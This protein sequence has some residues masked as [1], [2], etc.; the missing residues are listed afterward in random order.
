MRKAIR[1]IRHGIC[2]CLL[3]F[4]IHAHHAHA[5]AT[6]VVDSTDG[7]TN[8]GSSC[9]I[10]LAVQSVLT[11][12]ALGG[13][14]AGSPTGN[15]ISFNIPG[16]PATIFLKQPI[17]ITDDFGGLPPG[18]HP[19]AGSLA[20]TGQGQVITF[21]AS[22]M[23]PADSM[24]IVGASSDDSTR[25]SRSLTFNTLRFSNGRAAKGAAIFSSLGGFMQHDCPAGIPGKEVAALAVE[26]SIFISNR[27][28]DA[29]GAIYVRPR[30]ASAQSL[31]C[32]P[33]AQLNV[34]NS[35]FGTNFA[36]RCGG[37]ICTE[38]PAS[39]TVSGKVTK[40]KG[41]AIVSI[42]SSSF[43]F[44]SVHIDGVTQTPSG[45]GGAY[46]S[47]SL[48][49]SPLQTDIVNSTFE[50]NGAAQGA[51]ISSTSGNV[52]PGSLGGTY[53]RFVTIHHNFLSPSHGYALAVSDPINGFY[54]NGMA[55]TSSIVYDT[56]ATNTCKFLDQVDGSFDDNLGWPNVQCPSGNHYALVADPLFGL[57][58][59]NG[60]PTHTWS[61][62]ATS[63]ALNELSVRLAENCP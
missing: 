37:A 1:F 3:G 27:S 5:I 39:I 50:N 17:R 33:V 22:Q 24:F 18:I 9:T 31:P 55:L 45:E 38:T 30:I 44:N 48:N 16:G 58:G 12:T 19:R 11:N 43:E 10:F 59:D 40:V 57:F 61:L 52:I 15:I 47:R 23:T 42:D 26:G 25:Y 28:T 62:Q 2:L 32:V 54:V 35:I 8:F 49:L 29:G 63:P 41:G 46:G 4:A 14:T 13:C 7:S 51:S 34:R 20:I 21:D 36:T 6:I 53:L 60:G 56:E